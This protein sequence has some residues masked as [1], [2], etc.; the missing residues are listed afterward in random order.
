MF[1]SILPSGMGRKYLVYRPNISYDLLRLEFHFEYTLVW[2][3]DYYRRREN[4]RISM[5]GYTV[6]KNI[7]EEEIFEFKL[8]QKILQD[9]KVTEEQKINY[10]IEK[11]NSSG[12]ILQALVKEYY[13]EKDVD[14]REATEILKR[15]AGRN[16]FAKKFTDFYSTQIPQ[17]V[18][19]YIL[20][21][22]DDFFREAY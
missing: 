9:A 14:K 22:P 21:N 1:W 19:T 11:I 20:N 18:K 12:E 3:R 15:F 7:S 10:L 4:E 8:F 2:F 17:D 13:S 6:V 16:E 5:V